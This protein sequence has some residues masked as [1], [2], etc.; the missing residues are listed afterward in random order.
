MHQTFQPAKLDDHPANALF[1]SIPSLCL[2]FPSSGAQLKKGNRPG[3]TPKIPLPKSRYSNQLNMKNLKGYA[4][5]AIILLSVSGAF[6]AG[7]GNVP[8]KSP[9]N[10][11]AVL[12]AECA[13]SVTATF[14]AGFVSGSVTCTATEATC[15]KARAAVLRCVEGAV[16]D[17][18][19]KFGL[20]D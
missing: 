20:S 18:K 2:V 7:N 8:G 5:L 10:N 4:A 12:D 13:V 14:S 11:P 17:F 16:D 9:V 1:L 19:K 3:A 15:D 6:A